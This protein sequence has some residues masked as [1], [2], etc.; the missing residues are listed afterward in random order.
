MLIDN[1]MHS[2]SDF[3]GIL[4]LAFSSIA[5][6]KEKTVVENLLA[7]GVIE[8]HLFGVYMARSSQSVKDASESQYYSA[9]SEYTNTGGGYGASLAKRQAAGTI[10]EGGSQATGSA[11]ADDP[12]GDGD[13]FA[14]ASPTSSSTSSSS[15]EAPTIQVDGGVINLGY[16]NQDYYQGDINWRD[17]TYAG[18]WE[19]IIGGFTN[20]NQNISSTEH[21]TILDTG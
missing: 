11:A 19:V 7:E 4:G 9:A 13:P 10:T 20:G 21:H 16:A 12:F 2:T 5:E 14:S 1:V 6:S 18:Y 8:N 17:L 3:D 15:F